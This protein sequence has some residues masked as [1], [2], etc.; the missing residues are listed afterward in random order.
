MASWKHKSCENS[1]LVTSKVCSVWHVHI[2]GTDSLTGLAAEAA[3]KA[4]EMAE[5]HPDDV[6]LV[7][8]CTSTPEDLFGSAPQ[9]LI[10]DLSSPHI[11]SGNSVGSVNTSVKLT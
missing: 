9:V 8:L 4:L 7:L 6:D 11:E 5:V 3:R 10:K 2:T 1:K